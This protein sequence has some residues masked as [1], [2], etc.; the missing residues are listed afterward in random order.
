MF[1]ARRVLREAARCIWAGPSLAS[2]WR[3]FHYA[4]LSLWLRHP[5]R[6]AL[7]V[8]VRSYTMLPYARLSHLYALAEQCNREYISG[9]FV[10]CGSY[11]GGSAAALAVAALN[12]PVHLF[13]SFQGCPAPTEF[14]VSYSG[15]R[16]QLGEACADET[17]VRRILLR[18]GV[19]AC[20]HPGWFSETL[21]MIG[22]TIGPI[23]LLHIDCDWYASVRECLSSLWDSVSHG[24]FIV[25]DDFFY[26]K[27]ANR[28]TVEFFSERGLPMRIVQ[29]DRSGGWLR[30]D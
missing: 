26:W 1:Q 22:P 18:L 17:H 30:K 21:G 19:S 29:T 14:D 4:P 25:L 12:R 23:A 13:D 9:A 8:A 24:G 3:R 6:A 10:E 11:R 15:R 20:V 16:G 28:A 2:K 5:R 27:G 7:F